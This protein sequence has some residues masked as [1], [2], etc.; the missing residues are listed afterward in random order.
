MTLPH[1][2]GERAVADC[3]DSLLLFFGKAFVEKTSAFLMK[4][5]G[6][7]TARP[8]CKPYKSSPLNLYILL[9]DKK[10]FYMI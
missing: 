2:T 9:I 1:T 5:S 6:K 4:K 8:L 3:G 10:M 7:D